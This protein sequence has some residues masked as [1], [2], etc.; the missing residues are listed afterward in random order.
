LGVVLAAA[1]AHD[2]PLL[3]PTLDLLD[4]LGPL[5][6]RIRVHLDRGYDHAKIREELAERG[7]EGEIAQRGFPAPAQAGQRWP[8]ERTH[9]LGNAFNRLQRCYERCAKVIDAF[10]SLA[11]AIITLRRLIRVAWA[12]YRWD[13]RPQRC[14]K[15]RPIRASS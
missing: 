11:H 4:G 13:S 6:E 2:S 7:L 10:F 9:A 15:C 1:N 5:P 3:A 8:V 12:G 14:P